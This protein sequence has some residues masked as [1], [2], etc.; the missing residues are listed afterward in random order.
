LLVREPPAHIEMGTE[1]AADID[2]IAVAEEVRHLPQE[3]SRV[4]F[5]VFET[6]GVTAPFLR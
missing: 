4:L 2:P 3:D 6:A 1:D 5:Q